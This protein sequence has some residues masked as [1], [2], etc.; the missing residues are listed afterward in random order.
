MFKDWKLQDW[1][2]LAQI[3]GL[4]GL[5]LSVALWYFTRAH[6]EKFWQKWRKPTFYALG[7]V[8]LIGAMYRGWFAWLAY[9]VGLPIWILTVIAVLPVA[10]ALGVVWFISKS[11]ESAEISPEQ[12]TTDTIFNVVWQWRYNGHY[13][14]E[15]SLS[16]FCPNESCK[17]RLSLIED[18][19]RNYAL[20]LGQV[21]VSLVCP[22]CGFRENFEMNSDG[23]FSRV[24][25]EIERRIRTGDYKKRFAVQSAHS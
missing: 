10:L 21:P 17:C 15:H 24:P 2:N 22:N 13:I 12:Y 5:P 1:A 11:R 20:P 7:V 16:P 25:I 4:L 18:Y 23:L 3:L 6:F 19:Q 9:H 8:A 14:D